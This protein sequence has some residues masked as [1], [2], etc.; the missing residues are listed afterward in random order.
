MPNAITMLKADH[1]KV[2]QLLKK[3]ENTTSRSSTGRERL[4]AQIEMEVTVHTTLEE[5]VFYPAF[6]EA[7]R[8]KDDTE[9]F[10]EATEEHHIVDLVMPELKQTDTSSEQFGAKAKVLKELIEHH[11]REEEKEML[12]RA[13]ELL[14]SDELSALGETMAERKQVLLSEWEA[15]EPKRARSQSNATRR[16]SSRPEAS[17]RR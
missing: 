2:K 13:K 9:M 1:V 6:H 15:S 3:L 17:N 7:A 12:P 8:K 10:F 11:I 4:L 5:E 14:S 16:G